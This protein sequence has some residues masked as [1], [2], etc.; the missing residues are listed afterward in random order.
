[1]ME[2][3]SAC[4][5]SLANVELHFENALRLQAEGEEAECSFVFEIL[6]IYNKVC[7]CNSL[8]HRRQQPL[9]E[10]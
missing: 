5:A 2:A 10:V 3:T 9:G 6:S 4:C 7:P 8:Q 1:M